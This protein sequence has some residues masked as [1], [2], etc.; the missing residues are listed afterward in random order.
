MEQFSEESGVLARDSLSAMWITWWLCPEHATIGHFIR[1]H[2]DII[3]EGFFEELRR[4][5]IQRC[6]SETK[7]VAGDGTI[8]QAAASLM[9]K[10]K[11]EAALEEAK[12]LREKAEKASEDSKLQKKAQ[13][14]EEVV[15]A[16]KKRAKRR[17]V[18]GE[19]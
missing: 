2:E 1:R 6:G 7:E 11:L 13:R 12:E 19:E 18:S 5:I 14:P 10:N 16:I 15:D 9:Q 4:V 8:I 17:K 3:N